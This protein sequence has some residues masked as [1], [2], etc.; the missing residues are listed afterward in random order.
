MNFV[1]ILLILLIP[2]HI[3]LWKL[4]EKA[5]R[6][7]WES[8]I[9]LY[10]LYVIQ[11]LTGKPSYWIIA[12]IFPGINLI[13]LYVMIKNFYKVFGRNSLI[14]KSLGVILFFIYT[15]KF[16]FDPNVQFIPADKRPSERRSKFREWVDSAVYAIVAVTILKS[17]FL[18]A[19]KIPTSSMEETMLIGDFLFV[20]KTAYGIRIPMTPLTI[21]FTHSMI[22]F[23]IRSFLEWPAIPYT[24]LPFMREVKNGDIFVFN[25]PEGDTILLDPFL[26]SHSYYDQARK[27]AQQYRENDIAAGLQPREDEVYFSLGLKEI[28][29][30]F[31]LDSRPVDKR[32][33]YIKRCVAVAGDL[34]EIR[35]GRL[36]I[37][38]QFV[39]E[40][41]G[42]Q[43]TYQVK[44]QGVIDRKQLRR[45]GIT[46]E[47]MED[48]NPHGVNYNNFIVNLTH[49]QL[50]KLRNMPGIVSVD[51]VQNPSMPLVIF[52]H[53][54]RYNWTL[55][56]FGPLKIPK[57]GDVVKLTRDSL[58]FYE[59]IIRHYEGNELDVKDGKIYINGEESQTY[60]IKMN[61]YWAMGDNRHGS[62]DSRFWGFV[63]ENH[64]VG[65]AAFTFFSLGEGGLKGIRW[66]RIFK[67]F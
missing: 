5:G 62:L 58:C 14:D 39:D 47:D 65:K 6:K 26:Y 21:P 3:G 27:I 35:D 44:T 43:R 55:D 29:R 56:N 40:P 36:I 25:F 59:R 37:N 15:P 1:L 34:L 18:E 12:T 45:W 51:P 2:F 52:P 19:Y 24:R 9:P 4:F 41:E 49:A 32:E 10:D 63:P 54:S 38:G 30:R 7:G 28:R 23:P 42:V 17:Y 48:K 53:S 13:V 66:N 33:N 57:K 67:F 60:T 31:K 11:K 16:G 50:E 8:L 61:Y 46:R 20:N 64:L 22:T